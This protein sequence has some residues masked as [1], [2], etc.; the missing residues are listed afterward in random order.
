MDSGEGIDHVELGGHIAGLLFGKEWE[1]LCLGHSQQYAEKKG[2]ETSPLFRADKLGA[3]L[4]PHWLYFLLGRASGELREY[5]ERAKD[6]VPVDAPYREWKRWFDARMRRMA[7]ARKGE[8]E[9]VA[10][11]SGWRPVRSP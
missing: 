7:Y 4:V 2:L 11:R 9:P 8:G 5:R 10:L 6:F 1:Q 3:A